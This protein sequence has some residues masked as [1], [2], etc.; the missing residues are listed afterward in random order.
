MPLRDYECKEC[1][2]TWE[3]LRKDQSDPETC[4]FCN[5]N[6]PTR[7]LAKSNFVLKGNGWYKTDFKG[8]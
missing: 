4:K 3:E 1:K 6:N 7:L 2:E 8:K 5:A